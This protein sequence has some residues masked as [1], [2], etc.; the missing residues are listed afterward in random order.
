MT[1]KCL[2]LLWPQG[3]KRYE[4]ETTESQKRNRENVKLNKKPKVKHK[5]EIFETTS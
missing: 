4:D 1:P 2:P 3:E 5:L